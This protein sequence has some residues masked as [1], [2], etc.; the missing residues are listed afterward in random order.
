[1]QYIVSTT[2]K[3]AALISIFS[4]LIWFVSFGMIA[5]SG[6][7]FFWTTPEAYY[8]Y[9]TRNSMFWQELAKS[10]ML[11]FSIAFMVLQ[12]SFYERA[13]AAKKFVGKLGLVFMAMFTLS[14]AIHYFAQL[15]SVR[16]SIEQGTLQGLE[17][18][19]QANPASFSL[20]INML[21]WTLMLGLGSFFMGLMFNQSGRQKWF[22]VFHFINSF[23][24]TLALIG[25]T[26]QIDALTFPAINIGVGGCITVIAVLGLLEMK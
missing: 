26:L 12:F 21:G 1:M 15:S 24:C 25:F 4:I 5:A 3:W 2:G 22:K 17:H 23:F 8:D 6:P 11:I 9:F 16:L 20:A 14:S 10:F 7:L 18:F 19:L 13:E